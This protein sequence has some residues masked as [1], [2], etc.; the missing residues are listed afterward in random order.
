MVI[1]F[2]KKIFKNSV[3]SIVHA[4]FVRFGKGQ[5]DSRAVMKISRNKKIKINGTFEVIN[6]MEVFAFSLIKK[7][8][9]FGTI[10]LRESNRHEIESI[11]DIKSVKKRGLWIIEIDKEFSYEE[12]EKIRE[13]A[14]YVLMNIEGNGV[15]LK[16]KKIIPK[17][18]KGVNKVD[19][20]FF[21]MQIDIKYWPQ[22]KEEFLFDAPEGKKFELNH[23]Y[24]INEII[25]PKDE[26]DYE[27]IRILAKRKGK[28][29]RKLTA[30]G[31]ELRSDKEFVA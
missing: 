31:K 17:T 27:K 8:R 29:I 2:I 1:S 28:L 23:S 16:T 24:L 15:S 6:D 21:S 12:I 18:A 11:L 19:D 26:K 10:F 13:K 30:D 22:V 3:D 14:F 20:K 7:A 25:L 4:Q 9:A 5:F